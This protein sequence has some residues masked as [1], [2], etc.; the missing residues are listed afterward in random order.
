MKTPFLVGLWL[1]QNRKKNTLFG[2]ALVQIRAKNRENNPFVA[3]LWF[4]QGQK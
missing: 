3:G 1:G 4:E 2:K